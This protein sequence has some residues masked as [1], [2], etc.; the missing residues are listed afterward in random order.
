MKSKN[1]SIR[2]IVREIL[3][4]SDNLLYMCKEHNAAY[5]EVRGAALSLCELTKGRV[6]IVDTIMNEDIDKICVN[7]LVNGHATKFKSLGNSIFQLTE[8][9]LAGTTNQL[10]RAINGN[11]GIAAVCNEYFKY[12]NQ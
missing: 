9:E 11:T 5:E 1:Q 7:T 6:F 3:K 12:K 10:A 2:N 8:L 4:E